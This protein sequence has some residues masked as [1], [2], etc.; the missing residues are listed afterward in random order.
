MAEKITS[1]IDLDPEKKDFTALGRHF[2]I[3][4]SISFNKLIEFE[5][6]QVQLGFGRD[7]KA[8][9][10]KLKQCWT[11]ANEQAFGNVCVLL[12]EM[13]KGC[14]ELEK[15][16]YHIG[17]LMCTLF[18]IEDGE[19]VTT[20]TEDQMTAKIKCWNDAGLNP[21]SFFDLAI[22]SIPGFIPAYNEAIHDTFLRMVTTMKHE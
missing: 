5:R 9:F 10:A 8:M 11:E 2:T 3:H 20:I 12:Y 17:A 22:S 1:L 13:M 15:G 7:F 4:D 6:L 19:D 14:T 16:R 18:I 21:K